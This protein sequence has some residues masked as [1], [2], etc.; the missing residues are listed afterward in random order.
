MS[1]LS[2]VHRTRPRMTSLALG[3]VAAVATL[4]AVSLRPSA[5]TPRGLGLTFSNASGVHRTIAVTGEV[6]TWLTEPVAPGSH[7]AWA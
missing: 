4:A 3:A 7:A 6:D 5:A 2:P 1:P